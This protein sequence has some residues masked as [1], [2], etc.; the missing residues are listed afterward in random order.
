MKVRF[1]TTVAG[2]D[3]MYR[4][5][6]EV[7]LENVEAVRYLTAKYAEAVEEKETKKRTTR[8]K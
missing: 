1:L 4:K 7:D 2:S 3:F 8:K 5:G 6:Q